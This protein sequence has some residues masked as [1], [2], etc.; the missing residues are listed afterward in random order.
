MGLTFTIDSQSGG[1]GQETTSPSNDVINY[2]G[3][4]NQSLVFYYLSK[5]VSPSPELEEAWIQRE[6]WKDLDPSL[7]QI[8][9]VEAD[10]SPFSFLLCKI[11]IWSFALK[12]FSSLAYIL[13][14]LQKWPNVKC[15]INAKELWEII[16][17]NSSVLSVFHLFKNHLLIR[18]NNYFIKWFF[19]NRNDSCYS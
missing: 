8:V 17:R 4:S 15:Q 1:R 10:T 11:K 16:L 7:V 3:S 9:S 5:S 19:K 14:V 13:W 6:H 18:V 12:F 2:L